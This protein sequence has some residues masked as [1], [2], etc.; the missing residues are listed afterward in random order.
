LGI[1]ITAAEVTAGKAHKNA[2]ISGKGRFSLDAVENL[3]DLQC[4]GC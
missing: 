1:A 2:G 4:H 3:I